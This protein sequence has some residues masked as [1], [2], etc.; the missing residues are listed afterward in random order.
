MKYSEIIFHAFEIQYKL[1]F[2]EVCVWGGG[3]WKYSKKHEPARTI[4]HLRNRS[5]RDSRH[6]EESEL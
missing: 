1:K 3:V 4:R 2:D 5:K 6:S